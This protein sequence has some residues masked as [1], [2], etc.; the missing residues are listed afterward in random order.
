MTDFLVEFSGIWEP[1]TNEDVEETYLASLE[2]YQEELADRATADLEKASIVKARIA[3]VLGITQPRKVW[4]VIDDALMNAVCH[5]TWKEVKDIL[6]QG[7]NP[8]YNDGN[9]FN[10]LSRAVL[11]QRGDIAK[12]LID[13]GA[14]VNQRNDDGTTPLMIAGFVSRNWLQLIAFLLNRGADINAVDRDGRTILM[15]AIRFGFYDQARF[16]IERGADTSVKDRYGKTALDLLKGVRS[17]ADRDLRKLL[18]RRGWT[19]LQ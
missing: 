3:G 17:E 5:G 12:H 10:V 6:S 13:H 19:V 4:R 9:T 18:K 11:G 16:L 8:N 14:D 7:A 1:D 2:A 15:R